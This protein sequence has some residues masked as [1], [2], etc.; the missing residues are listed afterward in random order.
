MYVCITPKKDNYY[1]A[2]M[3]PANGRL[4]NT[5]T[6]FIDHWQRLAPEI[7]NLIIGFNDNSV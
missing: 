6:C 3:I 5:K 7:E 4:G 1:S 2:Q